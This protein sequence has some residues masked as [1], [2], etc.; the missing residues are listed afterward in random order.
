MVV[1]AALINTVFL[2]GAFNTTGISAIG[3]FI[4]KTIFIIILLSVLKALMA[5]IR[6]KQMINFSWKILM[7]LSLAQIALNIFI[8]LKMQ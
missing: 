5:R 6:I 8:K 2:G 3:L 4:L 7:P 1:G